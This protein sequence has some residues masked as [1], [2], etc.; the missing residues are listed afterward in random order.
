MTASRPPRLKLPSSTPLEKEVA[1][2]ARRGLRM[3]DRV[4]P[5]WWKPINPDTLVV[6]DRDF[7]V[8]AQA[9]HNFRKGII[10]VAES[11][12]LQKKRVRT[13]KAGDYIHQWDR[14][15]R[16]WNGQMREHFQSVTAES[17]VI[18]VFYY[19]FD[20][21]AELE[22]LAGGSRRKAWGAIDAAWR[23]IVIA[24]KARG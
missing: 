7:C 11:A 9:N 18:D 23:A 3:L 12:A 6:S 19:G 10:Q 1:K 22:K 17:S 13:L 14:S 20:V 5:E 21:D 15:Y 8:F 4:T 2:R 24:R 16:G